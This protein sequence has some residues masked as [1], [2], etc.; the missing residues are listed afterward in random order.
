MTKAS[1]NAFPSVLLTEGAP[2]AAPVA[3]K[4]RLYLNSSNLNVINSAGAIRVIGSAAAGAFVGVKAY[5]STT[6]NTNNAQAVLTMDSEEFDTDGFHSTSSQ[7]SRLTVP[8]GKG[9]YYLVVGGTFA[10][11]AADWVCIQVNGTHVRG[12]AQNVTAAG[13][14]NVSAIVAVSDGQYV[15]LHVSSTPSIDWGYASGT[16]PQTSLAMYKIG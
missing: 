10:S 2:P 7:T 14:W 11:G 15:E 1:D 12:G 16:D 3:G 5:N 9:G 8:A 6:Q 13:R 4:Q